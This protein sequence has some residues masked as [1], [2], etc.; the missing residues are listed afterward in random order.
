MSF[1]ESNLVLDQG[2]PSIVTADNWFKAW[3]GNTYKFAFGPTYYFK[4]KELMGFV[5]KESANWFVI[6]GDVKNESHGRQ[7]I[8]AGCQVH[9][10]NIVSEEDVS[11]GNVNT[12]DQNLLDL[13]L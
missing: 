7:Q 9:Y 5:P 11:E 12:D 8:I 6:V 10:A 13:T 2:R 1:I 3:D 4:A